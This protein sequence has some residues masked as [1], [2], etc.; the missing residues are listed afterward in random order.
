M[1]PVNA[2]EARKQWS[3]VIDEAVRDRPVFLKRTRDRLVLY[4]I[5]LARMLLEDRHFT[6]GITKEDNGTVTLSLNEL[7]L[8]ESAPSMEEARHILAGSILK[9][10]YEYYD[11][12]SLWSNAPERKHHLPYVMKALLL[13]DISLVE[14]SIS[15]KDAG[16]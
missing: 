10:A 2:T 12:F 5:G 14:E 1:V 15:C 9:Y 16:K 6:A 13:D 4:N 8:T 11:N 7:D 3:I